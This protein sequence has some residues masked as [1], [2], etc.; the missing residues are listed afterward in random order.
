M[1]GSDEPR[2]RREPPRETDA[3][4]ADPGFLTISNLLSLIRIPLGVTFLAVDDPLLLAVI[5][6]VGALTDLL[7]GF[8][9]RVTD[10]RTEIGALLD[11]F[12][13]RIFVF[14][15]LVSFLPTGHI[16]WAGFVILVLRDVFT[17][18]VF[19]V[20]K[21]VGEQMPFHSRFGGR[22][23]TALQV[24]ALFTLIFAPAYVKLPIFLVGF[25]SVYAII[26]YGMAG[27]RGGHSVGV[28]GSPSGESPA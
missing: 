22:A 13:D 28:V 23:T 24:V 2:V 17:G 7:D 4:S 26:D 20:T 8:I 3:P 18:G 6:A 14:L 19:I 25:A 21:L 10:T 16:D 5:V 15:G 12:C 1:T 9:A 27:V 11:P